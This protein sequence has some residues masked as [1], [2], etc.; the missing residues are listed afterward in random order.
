MMIKRNL[1]MANRWNLATGTKAT[2]IVVKDYEILLEFSPTPHKLYI[3]Q[4]YLN[5]EEIFQFALTQAC[6][7]FFVMN[8]LR[9]KPGGLI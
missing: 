9:K 4:N 8:N 6:Y 3:S 7:R 5:H 1:M 2:F